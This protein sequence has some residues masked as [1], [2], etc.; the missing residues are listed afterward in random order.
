MSI[1][2][3]YY[4]ESAYDHG[5]LC[6]SVGKGAVSNYSASLFDPRP[7]II[8]GDHRALH[9]CNSPKLLQQMKD[10]VWLSVILIAPRL[11]AT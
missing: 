8:R 4:R 11:L 6:P 9:Q 5:I 1:R 10:S 2:L 7:I 3:L